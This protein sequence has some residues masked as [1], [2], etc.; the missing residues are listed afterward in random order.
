MRGLF[1]EKGSRFG[2]L[3]SL[4]AVSAML[5]LFF[6]ALPEALVS[7][8]GRVFAAVWALTAMF[9]FIDNVRRMSI[10]RLHYPRYWMVGKDNR[11]KK[12]EERQFL[13]G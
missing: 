11:L 2:A 4:A 7:V 10:P 1:K 12:R 3:V 5:A 13:R 8:S 9:I 6:L